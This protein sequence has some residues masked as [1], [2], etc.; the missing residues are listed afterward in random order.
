VR[1]V[2]GSARHRHREAAKCRIPESSV[3]LSG[4][5]LKVRADA[6]LLP[7]SSCTFAPG[8]E[9]SRSPSTDYG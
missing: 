4:R 5:S 3:D 8:G 6:S 1:T 9:A 7:H 2:S